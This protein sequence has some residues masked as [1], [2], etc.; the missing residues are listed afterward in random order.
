MV[1][2]PLEV[3]QV[4]IFLGDAHK[5]QVVTDQ[6]LDQHN[7]DLLHVMADAFLLGGGQQSVTLKLH[8]EA[9]QRRH[10]RVKGKHL[11]SG[12]PPCENLAHDLLEQL[13][14]QV[15]SEVKLGLLGTDESQPAFPDLNRFLMVRINDALALLR[16]DRL[17]LDFGLEVLAADHPTPKDLLAHAFTHG[18]T[19][20]GVLA[21]CPLDAVDFGYVD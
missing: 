19:Q 9:L 7:L 17:L 20:D 14:S 2:D 6:R 12:R 16:L 13:R 8:E 3:V 15:E 4:E 21:E 1:T 10:L 18:I 5:L 11:I